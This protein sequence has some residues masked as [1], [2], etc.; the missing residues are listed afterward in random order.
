VASFLI[1]KAGEAF[2]DSWN[3]IIKD[4]STSH[5]SRIWKVLNLALFTGF[6]VKEFAAGLRPKHALPSANHVPRRDIH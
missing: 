1:F 6:P 4:Y 5:L 2:T 3:I